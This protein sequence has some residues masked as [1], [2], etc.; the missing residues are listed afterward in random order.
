MKI[1]RISKR[2]ICFNYKLSVEMYLHWES[3]FAR[4]LLNTA[5]IIHDYNST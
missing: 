4:I 1:S 5:F 3:Q 2:N